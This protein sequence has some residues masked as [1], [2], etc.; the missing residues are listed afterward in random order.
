[1]TLAVKIALLKPAS[2]RDSRREHLLSADC[3]PTMVQRAGTSSGL[4]SAP[5]FPSEVTG[6]QRG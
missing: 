6:T 4:Q 5:S 1:M 3:V 2:S